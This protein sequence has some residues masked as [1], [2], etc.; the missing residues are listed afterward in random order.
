MRESNIMKISVRA[1]MLHHL[2]CFKRIKKFLSLIIE[3]V[4]E[5][6]NGRQLLPFFT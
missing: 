5:N 3:S 1:W 6:H 2:N 4:F